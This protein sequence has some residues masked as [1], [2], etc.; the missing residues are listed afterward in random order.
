M[1]N[2]Y[3][4]DINDYRKYGLLRCLAGRIDLV[5]SW[6]LT[7]DDDGNDGSLTS[8]LDSSAR[9]EHFD[10]PLYRALRDARAANRLDVAVAEAMNLLPGSRFI[11]TL[12]DSPTARPRWLECTL[13]AAGPTTLTFLDPDNGIEVKSV[14]SGSS[15]ANKYVF[16]DELEAIWKTGSSILVYQ[17]FPREN[18]RRF[19]TRIADR[20]AVRLAGATVTPISAAR[21]AFFAVAQHGHR[22]LVQMGV[23]EAAVRWQNQLQVWPSTDKSRFTDTLGFAFANQCSQC[24]HLDP[25][26]ASRC[27]AF[28]GGIPDDIVRDA[29]D[30]RNRH[31]DQTTAL[32]FEQM[33][34]P[35]VDL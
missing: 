5:V 2:Q 22:E 6:M 33:Q 26:N 7:P 20:L 10:P 15:K 21:L 29:F 25:Y 17:H 18:R 1:K 11:Q 16:W 24:A 13:A 34:R 28:P 9:W 14:S 35:H 8:Y 4:G 3:F 32:R 27:E 23:V 19:V 31:P 12:L 30:H